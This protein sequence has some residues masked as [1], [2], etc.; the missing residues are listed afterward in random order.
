[1]YRILEKKN[2]T[3]MLCLS[4]VL[5]YLQPSLPN[6]LIRVLTKKKIANRGL[7]KFIN[8]IKLLS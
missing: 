7:Y 6:L 3:E 1:M 8:M 4:I 5:K 2:G